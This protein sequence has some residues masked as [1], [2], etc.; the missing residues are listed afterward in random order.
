[1]QKDCDTVGAKNQ[2]RDI[3]YSRAVCDCHVLK[4]VTLKSVNSAAVGI[5]YRER[6]P[7]C[8]VRAKWHALF[9][10]FAK[11]QRDSAVFISVEVPLTNHKDSTSIPFE[12][13][14]TNACIC[15]YTHTYAHIYSRDAI[16]QFCAFLSRKHFHGCARLALSIKL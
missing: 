4:R 16:K 8:P 3:G 6:A 12:R 5:D 2:S 15:I 7:L 1:M 13:A 11:R 14:R 10:I 9:I